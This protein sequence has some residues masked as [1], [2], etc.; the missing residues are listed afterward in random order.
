MTAELEALGELLLDLEKRLMDRSLRRNREQ[1]S[2][3]L[4]EDFREF[5]SSGRIWNREAML[6]LLQ[7]EPSSVSPDILDFNVARIAPAAALVTYRAVGSSGSSL[8]SSVWVLE[9]EDW[10]I[11]FHQGTKIP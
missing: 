6:T 9:G 11:L 1:V 2:S 8:R 3:L 7:S 5:G 10:Q 4:H